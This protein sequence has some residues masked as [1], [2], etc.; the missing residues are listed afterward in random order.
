MSD[1]QTGPAGDETG[2]WRP[3]AVTPPQYGGAAYP[4]P[5]P[6]PPPLPPS[7]DGPPPVGYGAPPPGYGQPTYGQP[8]YAWDDQPRR[9]MRPIAWVALAVVIGIAG[10]IA[11]GGL[12][13]AARDAEDEYVARQEQVAEDTFEKPADVEG[14]ASGATL[15]AK[16][17]VIGVPPQWEG[18]VAIPGKD[19]DG[20]RALLL[21]QD[22]DVFSTINVVVINGVWSDKLKA[23]GRDFESGLVTLQDYRKVG[24]P[25]EVTVTGRPALRVDYVFTADDGLAL[26]ARSIIFVHDRKGYVASFYAEPEHFDD[27][28]G[29]LDDA[30]R[31]WQFTD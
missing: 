29:A 20:I 13:G 11:L 8:G 12:I 23:A 2:P 18:R 16:G 25:V 30:L 3:P 7:Y 5:V 19:A 31:A 15:Q 26:K 21:A 6:P 28:V 14:G 22:A 24:E 10:L 1:D 27:E 9:G 17:F 4:P